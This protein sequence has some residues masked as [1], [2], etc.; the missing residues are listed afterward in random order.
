MHYEKKFLDFLFQFQFHPIL[1]YSSI[2]IIINYK[3]LFVFRFGF[4][5]VV[6]NSVNKNALTNRNHLVKVPLQT[7]VQAAVKMGPAATTTVAM[8]IVQLIAVVMVAMAVQLAVQIMVLLVVIINL[9]VLI[10][11]M[12][13]LRANKE[14]TIKKLRLIHNI[15]IIKRLEHL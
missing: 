3:F 9:Q 4:K 11:K 12:V 13:L 15:N 10:W 5:I 1:N 2:I 8:V 14:T 6:Q 7:I